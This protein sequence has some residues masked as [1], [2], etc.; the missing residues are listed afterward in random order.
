MWAN[1]AN[2]AKIK[3]EGTLY[4]KDMSYLVAELPALKIKDGSDVKANI[5]NSGDGAD[6]NRGASKV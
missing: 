4:G 2:P 1:E 3:A 6:L 5:I